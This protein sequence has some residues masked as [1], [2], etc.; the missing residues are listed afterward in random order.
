MLPDPLHPALV[1]F[2]IAL[3]LLGTAVAVVSVFLRRWHLPWI[4]AGLMI[5][6][7]GGAVAATW[8]GEEDQEMAGELNENVEGVLDEHEEWGER[9]R[10]S[11][12]V[13]AVLALGAAL[14]SRSPVSGRIASVVALC[15]ALVS[16]FCVVKAGHF[17]GELVYK[18]GVGVN[19]LGAAGAASADKGHHKD[20]EKKHDD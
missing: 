5:L 14:L 16:S 13:A 18:H 19:V 11:A 4:A 3:I 12:L 20:R 7:A 6:G 15:A 10:N 8:S 2:P 9:A 1:H 17:G